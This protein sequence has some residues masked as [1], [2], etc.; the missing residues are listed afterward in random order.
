MLDL[1]SPFSVARNKPKEDTASRRK[2]M[3]MNFIDFY[4]HQY[5]YDTKV[6]EDLYS[7]SKLTTPKE[8]VKR[9]KAIVS[10]PSFS[11]ESRNVTEKA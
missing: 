8:N 7:L 3:R 10:I 1:R 9:K 11:Q 2:K 5:G 4:R 6:F